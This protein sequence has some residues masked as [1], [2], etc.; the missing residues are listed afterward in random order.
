M[1]NY[2]IPQDNHPCKQAVNRTFAVI[3]L[4]VNMFFLPGLGTIIGGYTS[5]GAVQL[6]AFVVS[7]P[8]C[9]VLIGIPGVIFVWL[10]A[11]WSSLEQIKEST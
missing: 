6:F 10:W 4:L 9:W 11:F 2:P 5:V 7:V 1:S 3:G 8:L